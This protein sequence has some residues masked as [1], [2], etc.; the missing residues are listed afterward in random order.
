MGGGGVRIETEDDALKYGR[1]EVADMGLT[2]GQELVLEPC[3][4]IPWPDR[5]ATAERPCPQVD[6]DYENVVPAG[7]TTTLLTPRLLPTFG[8]VFE[9]SYGSADPAERRAV[10]ERVRA[11]ATS[12]AVY[13]SES[14]AREQARAAAE[15]ASRHRRARGGGG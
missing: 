4:Q 11:A 5:R 15:S 2:L 12:E 3:V 9:A 10:L 7:L 8:L 1:Y 14:R 6:L 13:E